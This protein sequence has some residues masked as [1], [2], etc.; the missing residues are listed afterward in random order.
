MLRSRK[1]ED[2][3]RYFLLTTIV[4]ADAL[5]AAS[6]AGSPFA[7]IPN[8]G[9]NT[10]SVIDCANDHIVATVPV[11]PGPRG[12]AISPH[13]DLVYVV[14]AYDNGIPGPSEPTARELSV[15][16]G[17]AGTVVHRL[18]FEFPAAGVATSV[19]GKQLYVTQSPPAR[20]G[21]VL[22]ID[23]TTY[24]VVDTQVLDGA[25]PDGIAVDPVD[26][27][28]YVANYLT[29]GE[30]DPCW[31]SLLYCDAVVNAFQPTDPEPRPR[32]GII[33]GD[34]LEGIAISADGHFAYVA[35]IV[36]AQPSSVMG[37]LAVLDL[38]LPFPRVVDQIS[39]APGDSDSAFGVA[40][41]PDG[42]RAYVTHFGGVVSVVDLVNRKLLHKIAVGTHP[43]GISITSD[44]RRAYVANNQSDNVSVIDTA[45]D[46]VVDTIPVGRAPVAFGQFIG[47]IGPSGS[48]LPTPTLTPVSRVCAGDCDN[49]GR[50]SIDELVVGVKIALG[51]A[52]LSMCTAC[53][54]D[55][56]GE[57]MIDDLVRA[58]ASALTGCA[59]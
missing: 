2:W 6:S 25:Y 58:V 43:Q 5:C 21:F 39:L 13:G 46:T 42:R 4:I 57:V 10:V 23:A 31:S 54:P 1:G 41:T 16:D 27:T 18:S 34:E 49:S 37:A 26:G 35:N 48:S 44:G 53:D 59:A 14:G 11:G 17:A 7:Y 51:A 52:S 38:Q 45:T 3:T 24:S 47:P 22:I 55:G 50:V 8:A 30:R 29:L 19:D 56:D 32:K 36:P 12:V 9:D 20:N 40:L 28:A 33:V 15:I